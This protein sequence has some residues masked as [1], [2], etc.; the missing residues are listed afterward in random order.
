MKISMIYRTAFFAFSMLMSLGSMGQYWVETPLSANAQLIEKSE[1]LKIKGLYRAG[2]SITDTL[3]LNVKG[4]LD[5]FSNDGPYPDTARWLNNYVFINRT[6]PIA[7]PTLGV[8]TFDGL[9]ANGYPYNFVASS[10]STG[11]ADTLTS[12]P[13]DLNFPGDTSVYFSFYYQAQGRGNYP[14]LADSVILEFK[15]PVTGAWHHVWARKGF[16]GAVSD[17]GWKQVMLHITDSAFLKKGFQFR[18]S[19]WATLSGN[20]DHWH[21]DYVYLNKGRSAADTIFQDDAFV[22]NGPSLI[23]TYSAMPWRQYDSTLFKKN[24][25]TSYIRNN[26]NTLHNGGFQYEIFDE[27]NI[28]VN[29]TYNAGG[30]DF[31][32][33]S[34]VGYIDGVFDSA[35]AFPRLNYVI[36]SPLTG[37]TSYTYKGY[38]DSNPNDTLPSDTVVHK[39]IFDNYFAYDDGSAEVSFGLQGFLHAQMAERFKLIAPDT[40]RCIDIYFNPQWTNAS[41]Y[42]FTLMVWG[43]GTGVPGTAIYVNPTVDAPEYNQTGHDKFTRYTLDQ[44]VVMT[45]GFFYVGFDQNT[46]NLI[47]IGVDKNI[48]TQSE[49]FYRTSGSWSNPPFTGSLMIR[50]VFGSAAEVVGIDPAPEVKKKEFVVFP[51]PANDKLYIRSENNSAEK[52]RYSVMDISGRQVVDN[53]LNGPEHIDLSGL[54]DGVYFIR[55]IQEGSVSTHKFIISK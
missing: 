28:Q 39:Q 30:L 3:A 8:A 21:L 23:K 43:H 29:P 44:P 19:N 12:K 37:K 31:Y 26:D 47:N 5:D 17:S 1:E 34:T 42:T 55:L 14:D 36:P 52:I 51:N 2:G 9:N 4:F 50:P 15:A 27:N 45:P 7:P 38:L 35:C 16:A 49:I 22:Y 53:V 33:Y 18:F 48:N 41:A 11:K 6:M 13:I 10:S 54:S 46:T 40:L 32:P 25:Y 24:R 20:G